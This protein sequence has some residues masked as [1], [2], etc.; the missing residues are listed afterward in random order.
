[1]KA[2][3]ADTLRAQMKTAA[4]RRLQLNPFDKSATR[5]LIDNLARNALLYAAARFGV[6]VDTMKVTTIF[7]ASAISP[8]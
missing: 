7:A 3:C 6:T 5:R 1:M 2:F 4:R 8:I